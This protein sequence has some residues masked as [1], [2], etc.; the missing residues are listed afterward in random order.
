V[1]ARLH[2]AW[3]ADIL[4][5]RQETLIVHGFYAYRLSTL[6][7]SKKVLGAIIL[8]SGETVLLH[9]RSE[10]SKKM[11]H[12]TQLSFIQLGGGI[13]VGIKVQQTKYYSL[14]KA[15]G[16]VVLADTIIGVRIV[17]SQIHSPLSQ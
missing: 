13:A 4:T 14:L 7:R 11:L 8:V 9:L 1:S 12:C 16:K 2:R 10:Y 15:P 5:S 6:A 17:T 3:A